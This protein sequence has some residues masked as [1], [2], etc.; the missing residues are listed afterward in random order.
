MMAALTKQAAWKEMLGALNF[1]LHTYE[2]Y[3]NA[4]LNY[5]K[6]GKY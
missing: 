4:Y 2:H 5:F 6:F 1:I 3:E